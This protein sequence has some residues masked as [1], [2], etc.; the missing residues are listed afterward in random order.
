MK[1]KRLK[2][3]IKLLHPNAIIPTRAHEHDA[4]LDLYSH[5]HAVLWYAH[6]GAIHTGVAVQIPKGCVGLI[7][8]RSSMAKRGIHVLGG[9]IDSGYTG[10]II[11]FLYNTADAFNISAGEKIAQLIVI[12][13][14]QGIELNVVDSLEESDRGDKGFGSSDNIQNI[15]DRSKRTCTTL[16]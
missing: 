2:L 9:V 5:E 4:G 11:V 13:L 3:N 6:V 12:P 7:K 16:K 10:E 14:L 15:I 1:E 8:D